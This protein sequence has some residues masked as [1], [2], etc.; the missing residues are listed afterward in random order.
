MLTS[1]NY[2]LK[3]KCCLSRNG[4]KGKNT[5]RELNKFVFF[6]KEIFK[7][8]KYVKKCSINKGNTLANFNNDFVVSQDIVL[9]NG[10]LSIFQLYSFSL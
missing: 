7:K 3:F 2:V 4:R 6:V 5:R 10:I 8:D 9:L 1:C